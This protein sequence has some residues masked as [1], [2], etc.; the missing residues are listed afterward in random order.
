MC[1]DIYDDWTEITT[2]LESEPIILPVA[3]E[4]KTP[5]KKQRRDAGEWR[6]EF[7]EALATHGTIKEAAKVV[8]IERKTV[9][10]LLDADESFRSQL[11]EAKQN[12]VETLEAIAMERIRNGSDT[13]LIFMLKGAAPHKYKEGANIQLNNQNIVVDL[14]SD[15]TNTLPS[16]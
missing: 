13:M 14:V 15:D 10:N 2:E 8:G 16:L 1:K 4:D 3:V 7:L 6:N 11:E 12:F 9:Y 5:T